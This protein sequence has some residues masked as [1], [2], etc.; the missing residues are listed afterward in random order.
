MRE[1]KGHPT[2]M[3][4]EYKEA[5]IEIQE[6]ALGSVCGRVIEDEMSRLRNAISRGSTLSKLALAC[7]R[8]RMKQTLST[9]QDTAASDWI[10]NRWERRKNW[11]ELLSHLE[12]PQRIH[13][14]SFAE[15]VSRAYLY[16]VKDTCA[17]LD[18]VKYDIEVLIEQR[19]LVQKVSAVPI[20]AQMHLVID[21]VKARFLWVKSFLSRESCSW[22]LVVARWPAFQIYRSHQ[23]CTA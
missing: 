23:S 13:L 7:A 16:N 20:S 11:S 10:T 2:S 5:F 22:L 18:D 17:P 9:L 21:Y 15:R 3:P 6:Y 12:S 19:D 4:H 1:F 14:M 8:Q